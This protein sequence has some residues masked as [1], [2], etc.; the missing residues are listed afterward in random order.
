LTPAGYRLVAQEVLRLLDE[1]GLF[2]D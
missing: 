1:H 2:E